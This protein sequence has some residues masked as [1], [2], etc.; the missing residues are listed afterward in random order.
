[1]GIPKL[2]Q[3]LFKQQAFK[4]CRHVVPRGKVSTLSVDMNGIIHSSLDIV[5]GMGDYEDVERQNQ[6]KRMLT[7]PLSRERN[8]NEKALM[9][10]VRMTMVRILRALV[11][12]IGPRDVLVVAVDGPI[13]MSKV[14]QQKQRR[15]RSSSDD[16]SFSI[17]NKNIVTPGT[18]FMMEI[19]SALRQEMET[20]NTTYAVSKVIYSSHLVPGEGEHKILDYFRSGQMGS[21][22]YKEDSAHIIYGNDADLLV[23]SL[24]LGFRNVHV[25]RDSVRFKLHLEGRIVNVGE[26][27]KE[28]EARAKGERWTVNDPH[29]DMDKMAR[30]IANWAGGHE[31]SVD[32]FV[33]FITL[34]G[35]DFLHAP[36]SMIVMSNSLFVLFNVYKEFRKSNGPFTVKG[37]DERWRIDWEG[38]SRFLSAFLPPSD[39]RA[40]QESN[41]K[42]AALLN[43]AD[44]NFKYPSRML[45]IARQEDNN[46]T[47]IDYATFRAAWYFNA[48]APV[49]HELAKYLGVEIR[50]DPSQI[51]DM[52]IQYLR[53]LN[54]TTQ[55]YRHG[56]ANVTWLWYYPHYHS[57]TLYD[58]YG[59][60]SSMI[61]RGQTET[62]LNVDPVAGESRFTAYHQLVAVL[63]PSSLSLLPSQLRHLLKEESPL[64]D[65]NP[66]KF[67]VEIDGAEDLFM[68]V[69]RV[70]FANHQRTMDS[71][72]GIEIPSVVL[73]ALYGSEDMVREMELPEHL[74]QKKPQKSRPPA[75]KED[76]AFYREEARRLYGLPPATAAE[77][78][79]D[80]RETGDGTSGAEVPGKVPRRRREREREARGN[81][82]AITADGTRDRGVGNVSSR[83]DGGRSGAQRRAP[84]QP[85]LQK[86]GRNMIDF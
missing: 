36:P 45:N 15:Y 51:S 46:G 66:R 38:F 37:D 22:S 69:A 31:G 30:V 29:V 54:W 68:G 67:I 79:A 57:P 13:P 40:S 34:V 80:Q 50:S 70:P 86:A 71:L 61:R 83:S 8:K 9:A 10:Q 33:T 17:L 39:K 63:P 75:T 7:Q 18:E 43:S 1:M 14:Q 24:A 52:C 5:Y 56:S 32:D 58:I 72:K 47:W 48:T 6:I 59:V 3:T 16:G 82:R 55:Y 60:L 77:A 49:N 44:L 35:N 64:A 12:E 85:I 53:G 4:R 21:P 20:A 2:Y 26:R 23:L 42:E 76:K 74:K 27:A 62:L 19:D 11:E 73:D 25:M 81:R 78:A 65:L 28:R 84:R 41:D